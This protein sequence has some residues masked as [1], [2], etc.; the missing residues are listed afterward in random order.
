MPAPALFY[1]QKTEQYSFQLLK[2]R[3]WLSQLAFLRLVVFVAF[4]LC[5]Y[6]WLNAW[7]QGWLVAAAC[8]LVLFIILVRLSVFE[9]EKT[10][11]LGK[12]HFIN[13]NEL[14]IL[15][16]KPNQ[17]EDGEKHYEPGSYLADLDI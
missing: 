7:Q 9:K 10:D 8:A 3:R 5:F 14:D 11:W 13:K 12:L 1:Q 17:F 4:L 15:H 2:K 6:Q 16:G